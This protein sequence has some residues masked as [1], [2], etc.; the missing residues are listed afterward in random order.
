MRKIKAKR[1]NQDYFPFQLRGESAGVMVGGSCLLGGQQVL[2]QYHEWKEKEGKAEELLGLAPCHLRLRA[3]I[4]LGIVSEAHTSTFSVSL[5][6]C[7]EGAATDQDV[8]CSW[9]TEKPLG[10]CACSFLCLD[11]FFKPNL[12]GY[13]WLGLPV[14]FRNPWVQ[15]TTFQILPN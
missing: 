2:E 12:F 3:D 15:K 7:Q 10:F 1:P 14:L 13:V 5:W 11:S 6:P 4:V 9:E 8:R